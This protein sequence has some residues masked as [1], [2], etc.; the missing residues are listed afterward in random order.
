MLRVEHLSKSYGR[1]K[2]R[3]TVLHEINLSVGD[4]EL[5]GI[6]GESG[7]GKSTLARLIMRLESVDEGLVSFAEDGDFYASCQIVFQ[8]ASAAMNPSWTVREILKEPLRLMIGNRDAYILMMLGKVG[9]EESH[10]DRR[11]S[12]LSGGERQRVN[13]LRSMLVEPKL[14][15]CDE[16]VSNLDRLIQKEIVE[17]IQKMNREM[18]MAILFI[19]HDLKVVQHLCDRVYVMEGGRI[20]EESVKRNGGFS[21]THPYSLMLFE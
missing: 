18:G 10:L 9:L 12:E 1:G 4:G 7:S 6:V 3:K 20:V 19:S 2:R 15:I 16:I 14:L 17:L 13:L 11:P 8:N 21:F 5:V